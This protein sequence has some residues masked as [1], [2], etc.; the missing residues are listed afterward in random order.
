MNG[1]IPSAESVIQNGTRSEVGFK[2]D[3]GT[4]WIRKKV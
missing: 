4:T 1:I 2:N 3:T